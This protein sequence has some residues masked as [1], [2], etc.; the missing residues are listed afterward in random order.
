MKLKLPK[1]EKPELVK[2]FGYGI[3]E[4]ID[5]ML[6]VDSTKRPT[7]SVALSK[8]KEIRAE[9]ESEFEGGPTYK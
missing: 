2:S 1:F 5:Q 7:S 6:E 3:D 4:L 8:I 9:F